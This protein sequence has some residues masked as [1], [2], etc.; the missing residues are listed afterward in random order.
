V[1]GART[2]VEAREFAT[3]VLEPRP[4]ELL[5][6]AAPTLERFAELRARAAPQLDEQGAKELIRELKAVGGDLRALRQALTGADRGPELWA[7]LAA[8]PRDE[9]VARVSS[10]IA[11]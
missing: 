1:R 11:R 6:D 10:T 4:A 8:L 7:V 5:A 3:Q 9:A 2:L